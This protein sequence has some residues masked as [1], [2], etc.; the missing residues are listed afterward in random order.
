MTPLL[1]NA[2]RVLTDSHVFYA[3]KVFIAL[4]GAQIPA[5][6]MGLNNLSVTLV[7]GIIACAIVET[8]DRFWRRCQTLLVTLITFVSVSLLVSSAMPYP[9]LLAVALVA[10]VVF[11]FVVS[12]LDSRYGMLGFSGILLTV[13]TLMISS[14]IH[15]VNFWQEPLLLTAGA[16]WYGL[17]SLVGSLLFPYKSLHEQLSQTFFA[18]SRYLEAKSVFFPEQKDY[19]Q[20]RHRLALLSVQLVQACHTGKELLNRRITKTSPDEVRQLTALY[21]LAMKLHERS[22]YSNFPHSVMNKQLQQTTLLEGFQECLVK[23]SYSCEQ[24]AVAVLTRRPYHH[25]NDVSW[26]I[27]ALHDQL[28][29]HL[30]RQLI[31][32]LTYD[33]LIHYLQNLSIMNKQLLLAESPAK[34]ADIPEL[35]R[36]KPLGIRRT[37]KNLFH[38]S[39]PVFRH[40][41][42]LILLVEVSY[43]LKLV[44]PVGQGYW[45]MLTCLFVLQPSYSGTRRR[46][47]QRLLGTC[48][49]VLLGIPCL[50]L[51]PSVHAQL[52]LS[53]FFS[54]L[55]FAQF[56]TNYSIA[57]TGITLAVMCLFNIQSGSGYD[58]IIPRLINTTIGCSL[59]FITVMVI[60]PD[61]RYKHLQGLVKKAMAANGDYFNYLLTIP[62]LGRQQNPEY[63]LKRKNM[64]SADAAL[65]QA[66]QDV[67]VEPM[68]RYKKQLTDICFSLVVKNHG[69]VS[70]LSALATIDIEH[71]RADQDVSSDDAFSLIRIRKTAVQQQMER[72]TLEKA[73][74]SKQTPCEMSSEDYCPG[75]HTGTSLMSAVQQ[76]F[77]QQLRSI[78]YILNQYGILVQELQQMSQVV[79]AL[80]KK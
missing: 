16:V 1:P 23:L 47:S 9:I 58:I 67:Q 46:F 29:L 73:F 26:V 45:I 12:S 71:N 52:A 56:K 48:L 55:F 38:L 10:V 63:R 74:T 51:F 25:G 14:N 60:L 68:S 40:M 36:T 21:G 50:Y 8:D 33:S 53:A 11:C 17:V 13:Y 15:T 4:A 34:I 31:S 30:S 80:S 72:L 64:Y 70:F 19:T 76:Q 44:L 7:L 77:L 66:W 78:E 24:L 20:I 75:Y 57:V 62:V 41:I 6:V 22:A 79:S 28:D 32:S 3:L 5:Y 59:A 42:R 35:V 54:A 39:S 18:L 61:W 37:I 49:G 27:H 2:K 65:A 69:L 43:G